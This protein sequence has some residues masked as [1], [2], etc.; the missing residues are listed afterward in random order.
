MVYFTCPGRS[1]YENGDQDDQ[2]HRI[3]HPCR[4]L[5]DSQQNIQLN[6]SNDVGCQLL[7]A[8][9]PGLCS[10]LPPTVAQPDCPGYHFEVNQ[11]WRRM[12]LASRRK[13]TYAADLFPS[14]SS[15]AKVVAE[16]T[17][18]V[19]LAGLWEK[20]LHIDLVWEALQPEHNSLNELLKGLQ[21][22][23]ASYIAPSWSW[24]SQGTRNFWFEVPMKDI[25]PMFQD[26]ILDAS[27]IRP[28]FV[29]LGHKI[30]LAG[31]NPFGRITAAALQIRGRLIE[32]PTD[33]F[34]KPAEDAPSDQRPP[35]SRLQDSLGTLRLD[36]KVK[37]P[38]T[39]QKADSNLRLLLATT[40]CQRTSNLHSSS[41]ATL[42]T[43]PWNSLGAWSYG[44]DTE[45]LGLTQMNR[46]SD[47]DDS[48]RGCESCADEKVARNAWG[49]VLHPAPRSG[50]YFRVGIFVLFG[51]TG[52]SKLF[53]DAES[54]DIWLI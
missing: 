13:F 24:A 44:I 21:S 38:V 36:W 23:L 6:L 43:E 54:H 41:I 42:N 26:V 15:M 20:Q 14:I 9:S 47:Q 39:L 11:L 27:H 12:V 37:Q 46:T 4:Y 28:E 31:I 8:C 19:Y 2:G 45:C 52:G 49:L 32:L 5:I 51:H 25:N 16:L 18:D 33:A 1:I 17:S 53:T 22:P 50:E 3:K 48:T 10:R 7:S 40:C 35:L 29:I 30:T 34:M